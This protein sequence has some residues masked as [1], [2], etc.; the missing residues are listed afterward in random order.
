MTN[1]SFVPF[2]GVDISKFESED[3]EE[4]VESPKS[5][6]KDPPTMEI[7]N[8]SLYGTVEVIFSEPFL[9][10]SNATI[11][12]NKEVINVTVIPTNPAMAPV[13]GFDWELVSFSTTKMVL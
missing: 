3:L 1:S 12:V 11:N 9:I 7:E 5:P 13:L 6:D 10:P 4:L 8:I 2:A